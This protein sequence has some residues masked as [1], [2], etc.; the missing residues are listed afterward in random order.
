MLDDRASVL[1][2]RVVDGEAT[3]EQWDELARLADADP[4]LWRTLAHYQRDAA[5]LTAQVGTILAMA[6]RVEAP[7][8]QVARERAT[9]Q[10]RGRSRMA[11]TWG[12]WAAAAAVVLGAV[13]A[14]KLGLLPTVGPAVG[15]QTAGVP[16]LSTPSEL[17]NAYLDSGKKQGIVV[18]EV[19]TRVLL[20]QKP[21]DT[22][23]YEVTYLRQIVEKIQV[24]QLYQVGRDE[25]GNEVPVRLEVPQTGSSKVY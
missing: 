1:L 22:G 21:L 13:L 14:P 18:G 8:G 20:D 16:A 10:V 24:P 2:A 15:P 5:T 17:F 6:D 23:G 7:V 12:G 11:A 9:E 25:L 19:P 3:R 4:R